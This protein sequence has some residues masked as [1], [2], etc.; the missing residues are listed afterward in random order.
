[1]MNLPRL[2]IVEDN[3]A[4]RTMLQDLLAGRGF[5]IVVVGHGNDALDVIATERVDVV[6][7][8]VE[9]PGFS[10]IELCRW[11]NRHTQGRTPVW[12][13]TGM[14]DEAVRADAFAAGAL[15]VVQK[16]FSVIELVARLEREFADGF[17]TAGA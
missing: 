2:L 12:L 8:D 17:A 1:M 5:D 10:G 3:S 4:L 9:L 11:I 15:E 7:A 16:P 14:H 13:M 6:L